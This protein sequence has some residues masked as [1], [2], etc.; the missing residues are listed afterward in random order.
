ME[1]LVGRSSLIS[2]YMGSIACMRHTRLDF[3]EGLQT[4][5]ALSVNLHVFVPLLPVKMF[6]FS[7]FSSFN[8]GD[9]AQ[10]LKCIALTNNET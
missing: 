3:L 2:I 1:V 4:L 10:N 5:L 6:P 7:I 8:N 9:V